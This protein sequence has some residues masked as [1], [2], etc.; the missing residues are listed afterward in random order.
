VRPAMMLNDSDELF[1]VVARVGHGGA[2]V[3]AG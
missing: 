1:S 2:E 3:D